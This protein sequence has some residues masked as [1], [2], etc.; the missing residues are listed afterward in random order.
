MT[1]FSSFLSPGRRALGSLALALALASPLAL[2]ADDENKPAADEPPSLSEA[3]SDVFNTKLKPL[4]EAKNWD[5]AIDLLTP[6]IAKAEPNGYDQWFMLDTKSKI[7]LQKGDFKSS[8]EPMEQA[9]HMAKTHKLYSTNKAITETQYL[10]AE[11]YGQEGSTSKDSAYQH[12]MYR[13]AI[14]N[15]EEWMKSGPKLTPDSSRFYSGLLYQSAT[16][17]PDH[18]DLELIKKA[19]LA[20]KQGILLT[21]HPRD[22]VYLIILAAYQQENRLQDEADLTEYLVTLNPK[23]KQYWA[24]LLGAYLGLAAQNEKDDRASHRYYVRAVNT[25]ERAQKLGI[26]TTPKDNYNLV[27]I[28]YNAGQF[29]KATDLLYAGLKSGAIDPDIKN[30]QL[31][32]YSFQQINHEFDAINA[33]KEAASLYPNNGQID[34][35][36]GQ[37]YSSMEK[38]QDAFAAYKEAVKKGNLNNGHATYMFLAYTAFELQRFEDALDAVK[39]AAQY[40]EAARDNQMRGLRNGIEQAIKERDNSKESPTTTS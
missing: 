22:D 24:Q 10:L 11:I 20:A 16:A 5:G 28:Y 3:V 18:P 25:I 27:T 19:E 1:A 38:T 29:G 34:F 37:I 26:M 30:W 4:I 6:M 2:R 40:P 9:L 23:N 15:L 35:Q 13:H 17:V 21:L 7:Y 12:E 31:L 36:I 14:L 33:L 8:I 39:H 32:A